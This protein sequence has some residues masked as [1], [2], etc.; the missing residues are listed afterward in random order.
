MHTRGQCRE[1]DNDSSFAH[2]DSLFEQ[3]WTFETGVSLAFVCFCL[4]YSRMQ[5]Q[6]VKFYR[7][8]FVS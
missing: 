4:Q 7:A 1:G 3:V 2:G 6:C 5:R 8:V